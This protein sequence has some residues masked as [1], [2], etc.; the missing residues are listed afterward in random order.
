MTDHVHDWTSPLA[1]RTRLALVG[2]AC[3]DSLSLEQVAARLSF[4]QLRGIGEAPD[5]VDTTASQGAQVRDVLARYPG[6][7]AGE[8]DAIL[9][10]PRGIAG[11]AKRLADLQKARLVFKGPKKVCPKAQRAMSTWFPVNLEGAASGVTPVPQ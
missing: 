8:I 5:W 2:C 9:C 7:T 1:M 4:L 11:V 10:L 6:L 3:G